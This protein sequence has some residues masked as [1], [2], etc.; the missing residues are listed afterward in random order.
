MVVV[1]KLLKSP[2]NTASN[3]LTPV[4]RVN[5]HVPDPGCVIRFDMHP[6]GTHYVLFIISSNMECAIVQLILLT[7]TRQGKGLA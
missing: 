1:C 6:A 5:C 3:T 2:E 4:P 7:A